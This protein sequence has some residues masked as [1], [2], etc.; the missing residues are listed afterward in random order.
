[1]N[2]K[3]CLI[4]MIALVFVSVLAASC[5]GSSEGPENG[6]E[7]SGEGESD[8][9]ESEGYSWQKQYEVDLDLHDVLAL[10]AQ[11]VWAVGDGGIYFYDGSGWDLQYSEGDT[12]TV[13]PGSQ[14]FVGLAAYDTS[15]VWAVSWW[16]EDSSINGGRI[17]FFDGNQWEMVK[18]VE[19]MLRDITVAD[20]DSVWVLGDE[21]SED[22]AT[23]VCYAARYKYN[24]ESWEKTTIDFE[25][26]SSETGNRRITSVDEE[27]IWE[28]WGSSIYFY[29]GSDWSEP[30]SGLAGNGLLKAISA[31]DPGH[32]WSVD[33]EGRI[34]LYDGSDCSVQYEGPEVWSD[35]SAYDSSHVWAAANEGAI[36]FFDGESWQKLYQADA[37]F[38]RSYYVSAAGPDN[39]WAAGYR[40]IYHGSKE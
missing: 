12:G 8:R 19:E 33:T 17:Y 11:H 4:I 29:N 10:D 28:S 39:I 9:E 37:P 36:Y 32:V 14:H 30:C 25:G 6:G 26:Y 24:G 3:R 34:Y 13:A 7:E 31:A 38:K 16:K 35:I 5:G 2:L 20:K 27:H 15:N 22:A 23:M 1:M 21:F 40:D 18:E